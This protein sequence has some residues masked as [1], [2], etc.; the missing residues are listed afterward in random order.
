MVNLNLKKKEV[1]R[2]L[3]LIT[4]HLILT[5]LKKTAETAESY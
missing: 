4:G 2:L 5:F 3:G 1:R